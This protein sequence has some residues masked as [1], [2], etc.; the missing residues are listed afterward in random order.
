M[1]DD[2]DTTRSAPVVAIEL[3]DAVSEVRSM[4]HA[5]DLA[6]SGLLNV[7]DAD[8]LRGLAQTTTGKLDV[9]DRLLT[10]LDMLITTSAVATAKEEGSR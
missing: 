9:V 2:D 7:D 4:V 10:E 5:L 6:A 1:T 3:R 8:A